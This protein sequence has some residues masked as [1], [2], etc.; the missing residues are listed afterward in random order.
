MLERFLKYIRE[1]S[2]CGEGDRILL[3]VSGGMDS[4]SM[5][6]LFSQSPFRFGIAH[7]NFGLRGQESDDDERF[8]GEQAEKHGV[9]FHVMRFDTQDYARRKKISTQMAARQLRYDWFDAVLQREGYQAVAVAH[10]LNDLVETMLINLLRGTGLAGMHGILP[11]KGQVIRPLLCFTREEIARMVAAGNI[12]YREEST[13][14]SGKYTRNR[15]R[16]QVV[17]VLKA[18]NPALEHSFAATAQHFLEAEQVVRQYMDAYQHLL[19][20]G[21][22]GW[23]IS[24]QALLALDAPQTVLYQLLQPMGFNADVVQDMLKA[25]R[26]QPGRQF[27]SATHKAIKDRGRLIIVPLEEA[28]TGQSNPGARETALRTVEDGE[29]MPANQPLFEELFRTRV[30]DADTA[31]IPRDPDTAWLDFGKLQFPLRVRY[32]K[33]GDRFHP[34]GM[35]GQKKLS[36]FFVDSKVPLHLKGRIPLVFSGNEIAWVAGY[37]I[38]DP[39]KV[40]TVTKKVYEIQK[41]N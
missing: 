41:I 20:P 17:P 10:H 22:D 1:E 11:K 24:C 36:D 40:T 25:C 13:N 38:A 37:R 9:P 7:C 18:L 15:L 27:F 19:E 29:K 14:A 39:F 32:W 31:A 30:L 34:L 21:G 35:K 26:S 5:V 28:A 4:M 12:P 33:E 23:E 8:V 16:H 3:A 2:L 6:R